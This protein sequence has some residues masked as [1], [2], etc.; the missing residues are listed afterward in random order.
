LR[1]KSYPSDWTDAQWEAIRPSLEYSNGYSNGYGSRRQHFLLARLRPQGRG[2]LDALLLE[3]H[4][5]AFAGDERVEWLLFHGGEGINPLLG[6]HAAEPQTQ[7]GRRGVIVRLR[8]PRDFRGM[9]DAVA[10]ENGH[11]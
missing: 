11:G 10:V 7:G 9:R 4:L 3:H 8:F 5:A 2:A 6:V 1:E